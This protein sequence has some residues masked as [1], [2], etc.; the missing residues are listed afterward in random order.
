VSPD[1]GSVVV[2]RAAVDEIMPLRHAV[3]RPGYPPEASRYDPDDRAVHIGGWDGALL[4]A[5]ATVFADPWQGP[6]SEP[7]A[8]RLRGMAV[9]PARQGSGVGA[10]VLAAAVTAAREAGAPLMWANARTSAL[11]FY[12]RFGWRVAGEEFSAA[13]TGLPHHPIL[14]DLGNG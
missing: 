1:V 13:D 8:W 11:G 7:D 3:L 12:E 14:L 9:E 5:C 4:V 2:R 6:P 10:A